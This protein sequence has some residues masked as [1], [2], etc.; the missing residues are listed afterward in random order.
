M[1]LITKLRG[2]AKRSIK[3]L[4]QSMR[5]LWPE[6]SAGKKKYQLTDDKASELYSTLEDVLNEVR[7][8]KDRLYK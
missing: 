5:I 2:N 8:Y 1:K 4:E 6:I 7:R 3:E